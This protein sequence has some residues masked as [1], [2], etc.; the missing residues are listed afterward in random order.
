MDPYQIL[1]VSRDATDAEI[2]DAYR[3]LA[4]EFNPAENKSEE[5]PR[6]MSEIKTA[7]EILSDPQKRAQYHAYAYAGVSATAGE[8]EGFSG[9]E[10]TVDGDTAERKLF[11]NLIQRARM[12]R[13]YT[14][15]RLLMFPAFVFAASLIAD[16][17][18]TLNVHT[19]TFVQVDEPLIRPVLLRYVRTDNYD[20]A[21]HHSFFD[22][23]EQAGKPPLK[24]Y[25]T[26]IYNVPVKVEYRIRDADESA[27][28][29]LTKHNKLGSLPWWLAIGC[30]IVIFR[31]RYS[32]Q[33][34]L[35]AIACLVMVVMAWN[36]M[37]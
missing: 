19:E 3:R 32:E 16:R 37:T 18:L 14:Y 11:L 20:I 9:S 27:E 23:Y 17:Y 13:Y 12:A 21:V 31:W 15:I 7:Y 33:Y 5:A 36:R 35:I 25:V 24:L 6:R 29:S 26:P 10:G 2:R 8:E 30:L 28:I 34:L 1:G 4:I 22:A